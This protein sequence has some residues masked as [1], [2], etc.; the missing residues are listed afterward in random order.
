MGT[1]I[2]R[3]D[4]AHSVGGPDEEVPLFNVVAVCHECPSDAS[5]STAGISEVDQTSVL[6]IGAAWDVLGEQVEEFLVYLRGGKV[7]HVPYA[8]VLWYD[9]EER[10]DTDNVSD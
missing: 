10:I 9:T 7:R 3:P 5:G 4:V 6:K 2:G 8:R 1:M